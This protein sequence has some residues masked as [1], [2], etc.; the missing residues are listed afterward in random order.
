MR[1]ELSDD[2]AEKC[3][4]WKDG[5]LVYTGEIPPDLDICE[6]IERER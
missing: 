4:E 1:E 3:L 6:F 5:L 2:P